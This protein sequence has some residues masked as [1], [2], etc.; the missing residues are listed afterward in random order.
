MGELIPERTMISVKREITRHFYVLKTERLTLVDPKIIQVMMVPISL[1]DDVIGYD[2]E[3]SLLE[4]PVEEPAEPTLT[5]ML[6]SDDG[7]E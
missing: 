6:E 2:E 5:D 3:P 1:S 7:T 4:E